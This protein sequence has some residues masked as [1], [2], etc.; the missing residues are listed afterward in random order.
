MSSK[1]T[2]VV[3]QIILGLLAALWAGSVL[4][5]GKPAKISPELKPLYDILALPEERID[6][7]EARL[8]I[9]KF[10]DPSIDIAMNLKEIERIIGEIKKVP[11]YTESTEGKLNGIV[12]YLYISGEWNNYKPYRYDFDDPLGIANPENSRIS[13]YLKTRTGDCVSMPML[14]LILGERLWLDMSLSVA[15]LHLF[16]RLKDEGRFYNFEATVGGL[17][18]D[19][20]YV[21]ELMITSQALENGI[22]LRSLGKK[23]AVTVMLTELARHYSEKGTLNSDFDKAF[24]L[25]GLML[26]HDQKNIAAMI[27]RGNTWRNILHRDIE[28][29]KA[30]RIRMTPP[31]KKHFDALLARNLKWYEKAE[32]LGWREPPKDYDERYLKTINEVRKF[33]E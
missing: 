28:A 21:K 11:R 29:F 5:A 32:A 17:K 33:Y 31:I 2:A 8:R 16:V 3:R 6:L 25:T 18:A 20:S 10:F 24:E 23:Q 7:A 13:H 14:V 26:E 27:I 4:A 19:S 12:Q 1:K 30:K 9:E 22:Y 15:P